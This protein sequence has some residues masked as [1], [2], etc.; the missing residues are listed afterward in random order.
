MCV[1][2]KAEKKDKSGAYHFPPIGRENVLVPLVPG[3]RDDLAGMALVL[4]HARVRHQANIVVHVEVEQGPRL[5]SGLVV[6]V[7]SE[8]EQLRTLVMMKS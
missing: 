4:F 2:L 6:K 7:S 3:P 8:D 1:E 5:A